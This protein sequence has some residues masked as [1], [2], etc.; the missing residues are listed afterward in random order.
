MKLLEDIK[1]VDIYLLDQLIKGRIN[2]QQR[3]L[4]AGCGS[5]RNLSFFIKNNFDIIGIDPMQESIDK[6]H[7]RFSEY[8]DK[9]LPFS[10]EDYTDKHGFDAIICNAVLHFA[11]GHDHFSVLFKQLYNNLRVNGVLF[12]RM[13]SDIGINPVDKGNNGVYHL[14]DG[15][16]RYLISK[17]R[18]S[19]LLKEYDFQLIEPIKT[20][21]VNDERCMTT[22]VLRK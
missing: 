22:L 11:T 12:I 10:I 16:S 2:D 8:Q 6:L 9:I 3:I 19:V 20:V 21:N 1:G 7:T 15:T 18:I 5:G 13:T 14:P 4:D 17:A